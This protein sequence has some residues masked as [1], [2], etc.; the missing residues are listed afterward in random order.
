MPTTAPERSRCPTQI[1]R[2]SRTNSSPSSGRAAAA[3][4]RCS[5]SS[6]GLFKATRG[7]VR[8]GGQE[9]KKPLKTVGMAFQNST[10]LPWRNIRDN[11]LLPLRD[12]RAI[13]KPTQER[14]AA[15][16]G[17]CGRSAGIGRPGGLRRQH[18]VAIVRR[19]AAARAI[20]PRADP[21]ALD[22]SARRAVRRARCVHAR[23]TVG[24]LAEPVDA[25][26]VHGDPGD[27]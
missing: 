15:Q 12:R 2:S 25:P 20:V 10:L 13:P 19:H 22:S 26:Q 17:D 3:S 24:R 18:A 21:R 6:P 1:C 23:G 27:A 8:V 7:S 5:S 14:N 11:V 4:R 16:A 9:V